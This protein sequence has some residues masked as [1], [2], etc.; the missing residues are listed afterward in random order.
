MKSNIKSSLF[1]SKIIGFSL[2][3]IGIAA[4]SYFVGKDNKDKAP[5]VDKIEFTEIAKSRSKEL[6]DFDPNDL[7]A[8][9]W[10]KLGF[11]EKQATT[12]LKYKEIVGGKFT[13]KEQLKKCY[14]ISDE[15]FEEL[16]PY[17]LLPEKSA[18]SSHPQNRFSSYSKPA[19]K[20]IKVFAKFNPDDYAARDWE[21][22]GFSE[23][24]AAAIVKY[25]NYLGGSFRSKEKFKECFIISN[26]NYK[27]LE[28][29]LL[30]PETSVESQT[31]NFADKKEKSRRNYQNFD[32]NLLDEEGWK[33]LGFSEKQANVIL[34]YKNRNLKG[35]FQN[36]GEIKSCF[37][38]SADKFAELEPYI[39]LNP[40]NFTE[41][42]TQIYV[43][44][45]TPKIKT[46]FSNTDLNSI[47]YDELLEFGFSPKAAGNFI[48]FRK[49]LG[50]FVNKNQIFES[51][52]IDRDLATELTKTAILKT[53]NVEK[54]TLLDAPE[55]W[56]KTHPYFKYSADK[57][58]Y[59]RLSNTNENKIWKMIKAKPEYEAKMRMYLK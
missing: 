37:V 47:T 46:N 1:K 44:S 27:K 40:N 11:S 39:T 20:E 18:A 14:S 43:K 54:Y 17:I 4:G 31:K 10:K 13:S 51:Y 50:G 24:Q 16:A 26:E 48:S 15:K 12:I 32:P 19:I 23:K 55:S 38:I 2:L 9:Q 29:Y 59:Y 6:V 57:I 58:I 7:N 52:D 33:N 3:G 56:L 25:R 45:E 36:L 28:P 34:N 30:I 42:K 35:S 53:E 49:K 5:E 8:E 41:R 21:N 22:L